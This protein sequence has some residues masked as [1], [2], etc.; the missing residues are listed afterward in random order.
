MRYLEIQHNS[1]IGLVVILE[2]FKEE[3]VPKVALENL[4]KVISAMSNA[5]RWDLHFIELLSNVI[6]NVSVLVFDK[7]S[8]DF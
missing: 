5:F 3:F 6:E 2:E 8:S 4:S 1:R 7:I